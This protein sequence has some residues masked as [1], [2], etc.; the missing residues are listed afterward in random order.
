MSR[1]LDALEF[2]KENA[3]ARLHDIGGRV[4]ADKDL[5][6]YRPKRDKVKDPLVFHTLGSLADWLLKD[7]DRVREAG[8]V[9]HVV[10]PT[11][12]EVF[13]R[14]DV[15]ERNRETLAV[16]QMI[17]I[18]G[19]PFNGYLAQAEF[20]PAALVH[21]APTHDQPQLLKLVGTLRE[22]AATTMDD[23]GVT[24]QVVASNGLRLGKVELPNPVTLQPYR[25]FAEVP[26]P[27]SRFIVRAQ[28]GGKETLPTVG[29]FEVADGRWR[30]EAVE[31]VQMH[32]MEALEPVLQKGDRAVGDD[33]MRTVLVLA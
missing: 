12:V 32:L 7:F 9:V 13:N 29:L 19:F 22:E 1:I 10:S 28:G 33:P 3:P 26:Q 17:D 27:T 5:K 16:A 25:T 14:L 24:Q 8:V 15:E 4:Y 11:L 18:G 23:D 30:L 21:L 20:V 31:S 2:A 6:E